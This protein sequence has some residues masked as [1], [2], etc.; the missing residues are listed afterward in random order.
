MMRIQSK[1]L[2]WLLIL[3]C[4][5]DTDQN[6]VFDYDSGII[7]SN[8][9]DVSNDLDQE[10][11][12]PIDER[13]SGRWAQKTR[14]SGI[15]EVPV[16]G[17]QR[18]DTIGLALVD[19][20]T[21]FDAN[22]ATVK[23]CQTSIERDDDIVTTDIP[24]AFIDSLPVYFRGVFVSD[25]N[26]KFSK[27]VELSGVNLKDP[28]N[29]P[30]PTDPNDER[31]YDQDLD[32]HP[33]VTVFVN[34]LV[35]GQIHLIQRTITDLS[36]IQN[37]NTIEGQIRWGIDESILGTD[38]PLLNMGAPITPNPNPELSNF[39]LIKVSDEFTCAGLIE[40]EEILFNSTNEPISSD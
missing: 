25:N 9:A 28:L 36:G 4:G 21:E 6:H 22:W 10:T 14:L 24:Q 26:I 13:L 35:S 32:G 38:Q 3:A 15:A 12:N 37:G 8:L 33:G 29:D 39:E 5:A 34:G 20:Y 16:L 23:N 40:N 17:F 31:I 30:L 7:E 11:I 19:I 1:I 18:T 27:M 2:M